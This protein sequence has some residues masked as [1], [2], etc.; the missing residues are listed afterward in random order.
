MVPVP[1]GVMIQGERE[2]NSSWSKAEARLRRPRY[3]CLSGM[4]QPSIIS[5][6]NMRILPARDELSGGG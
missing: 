1:T 5:R 3:L 2:F 6:D 4:R